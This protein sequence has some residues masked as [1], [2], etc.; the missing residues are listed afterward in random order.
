MANAVAEVKALTLASPDVKVD[1]SGQVA[2]NETASSNL[3]YRVEAINLPELAKLAGQEPRDLGPARLGRPRPD[4]GEIGGD[5]PDRVR[6]VLQQ[7]G[8]GQERPRC[9]S[10]PELGVEEVPEPEQERDL[11]GEPIPEPEGFGDLDRVPREQ[12]VTRSSAHPAEHP[13]PEREEP[14]DPRILQDEQRRRPELAADGVHQLVLEA[15]SRGAR[16]PVRR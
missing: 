1:A 2:L 7:A 5:P 3:K 12:H 8:E 15:R 4:D 6:P 9:A 14:A 11:P 16:P 13:C 10:R